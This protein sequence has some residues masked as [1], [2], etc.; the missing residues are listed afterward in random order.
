[1]NNNELSIIPPLPLSSSMYPFDSSSTSSHRKPLL[2]FPA[3]SSN[4]I[5]E[6]YLTQLRQI[7]ASS[8]NTNDIKPTELPIYRHQPISIHR[9]DSA[10]PTIST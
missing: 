10:S 5:S 7:I 2:S 1:V 6:E 8:D 9:F 4:R 3:H